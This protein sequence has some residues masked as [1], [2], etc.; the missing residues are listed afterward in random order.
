MRFESVSQAQFVALG[1]GSKSCV[2]E[3]DSLR[4]LVAADIVAMTGRLL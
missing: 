1:L 3:L 4:Q 2:L